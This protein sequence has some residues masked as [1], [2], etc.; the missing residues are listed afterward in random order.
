[1]ELIR[2]DLVFSYWVFAW[3]LLY[4]SSITL[5]N[6]KFALLIGLI[7]NSAYLFLMIYFN[8]SLSKIILFIIIN[9]FIKII[10]LYTL[11]KTKYQIKD[12]ISTFVLFIIYIFWLK[13]NNKLDVNLYQYLNKIYKS[14]TENKSDLPLT[15]YLERVMKT[16]Y[17]GK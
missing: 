7:E 16:I 17:N 8:N 14:I 11:I 2:L 4:I 10:P 5:F 9:I 3:Y 15:N 13:I 1:M 6:P 12:V